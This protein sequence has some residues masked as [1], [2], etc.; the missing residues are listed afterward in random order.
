MNSQLNFIS[1]WAK[2]TNGKQGFVVTMFAGTYYLSISAD[3]ETTV[4][5]PA[6][7]LKVKKL[8]DNLCITN[9]MWLWLNPDCAI[10]GDSESGHYDAGL[11]FGSPASAYMNNSSNSYETLPTGTISPAI[12]PIVPS[13][14]TVANKLHTVGEYFYC[15]TF[16]KAYI[17]NRGLL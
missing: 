7:S 9:G 3:D 6:N 4:N 15:P 2:I 8:N 11:S 12:N 17:F 14:T 10:D 5:L 1:I 16:Y 13:V